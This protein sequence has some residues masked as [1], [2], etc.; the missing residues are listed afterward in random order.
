MNRLV[1]ARFLVLSAFRN[2]WRA[3]R[4]TLFSVLA[5]AAAAASMLLFRSFVD[6]VKSQFRQN[7][8]TSYFG[9]YQISKRGYRENKGQDP[10][11]YTIANLE[12]LRADIEK[13]V[14]SLAFISRRQPFQ[15]LVSFNDRSIGAT[16]VGIDAKEEKKFLTMNQVTSGKHL[17]DAD[18]DGVFIGEGLAKQLGVKVGDIVTL[19][20]TTAQGSINAVDLTM[21]GT[22]KTGVVEL[23]D[24]VFYV[25]SEVPAKLLRIRGSSQLLLG[26]SVSDELPLRPQLKRLLKEKYPELRLYHWHE[27]AGDMYDNSIGWLEGIFGVLRL[28]ILIVATLSIINVFSINL[29]ERMGEFGTLRAIGTLPS[30]LVSLIFTESL[31]QSALGG[32]IGVA[33]GALFMVTALKN[34]VIM[35]PP[36]NMTVPFHVHFQIPWGHIPLTLFLCGIVAGGAGIFPAIK[37]ARTNIVKALGRNV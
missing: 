6:G 33:L 22:F 4:R 1:W 24:S 34:G 27:L 12:Q 16:G 26:F 5:I 36:L 17:A 18:A 7:L 23:D 25:H 13:E 35:P 8:I 19:L 32:L 29:L 21:T 14:G 9:H 15:T 30:Q 10:Y 11:G 31:I 2:L 28:I 20:A 37:M 3:P